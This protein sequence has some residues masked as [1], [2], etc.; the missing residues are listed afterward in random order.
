MWANELYAGQILRRQTQR[1]QNQKTHQISIQRTQL[2]ASFR[3]LRGTEGYP[4]PDLS[5]GGG[6]SGAPL[7][8]TGPTGLGNREVFLRDVLTTRA[9]ANGCG[10]L[11]VVTGVA[12]L[13]RVSARAA[14][15]ES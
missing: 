4:A 10:M 7:V 9:R 3:F 6:L 14:S 2:A 13:C 5:A 15:E 11:E 8:E 12:A 1:N